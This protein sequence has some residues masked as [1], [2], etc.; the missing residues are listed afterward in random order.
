MYI[1][2]ASFIPSAQRLAFHEKEK[3]VTKRKKRTIAGQIPVRREE[4]K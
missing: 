2:N 3:D 4:G 1:R